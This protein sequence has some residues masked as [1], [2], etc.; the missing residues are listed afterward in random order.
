M[1][2][3]LWKLAAESHEP[4]QL[5]LGFP[6]LSE[7]TSLFLTA[8]TRSYLWTCYTA[9][10]QKS[11]GTG[12]VQITRL[13]RANKAKN[14]KGRIYYGGTSVLVFYD[15]PIYA[16]APLAART[17]VVLTLDRKGSTTLWFTKGTKHVNRGTGIGD[18]VELRKFKV[19][20]DQAE[21]CQ[22]MNVGKLVYFTITK[23][24][25]RHELW[26]TDGTVDGTEM[27]KK[28]TAPIDLWASWNDELF[29]TTSKARARARLDRKQIRQQ[30]VDAGLARVADDIAQLARPCIRIH[31]ARRDDDDIPIGESKFGGLP[32]V[33]ADFSWPEWD[34]QPLAFLGQIK[35]SAIAKNPI[36]APLP[37]K[38]VLSFFYDWEQS[39]WGFDPK[40]RGSWRVYYFPSRSLRRTPCP[41]PTPEDPAYASCGL[42]FDD[43]LT[44]PGWETLYI[45]P[46]NLSRAERNKYCEF[47]SD[48]KTEDYSHQ[49]LGHPSE[50]QGEMQLQCQLAFHGV[51]QD[52]PEEEQESAAR[53]LESGASQ[54]R[55]LFQCDGDVNVGWMWGDAG[56][57]YFWITESD[58]QARR[59][60]NVWMVLQCG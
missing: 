15:R 9:T 39:T 40:D 8:A 16:M 48:Q 33:P 45:Q 26:R 2:K 27:I 22:M 4:E 17:L 38:G 13:G 11:D 30:L 1:S 56:C 50:I 51:N 42:R 47:T 43:G 35:L 12:N 21:K 58:L 60:E 53:E 23:N 19:G 20:D 36:A 32:D 52:N 29:F 7:N 24:T 10:H 25:K 41:L 37:S 46:L 14:A 59:F 6:H 31:T 3:K 44:F 18:A 49:L 55:L 5:G 34:G 57:L 28:Y 54:W